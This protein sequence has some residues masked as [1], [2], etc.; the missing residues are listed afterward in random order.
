MSSTRTEKT[1][2]AEAMIALSK[3]NTT[4]FRNNV[5][6]ATYDNGT[7]VVYGLCPG[8]SDLIGWTP[9]VVREKDMGRKIAI[10]TAVEMK[11]SA[12]KKTSE[13]QQ[14]FLDAVRR[15]GGIACVGYDEG[16]VD[17]VVRQR[18]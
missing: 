10:F 12:K 16:V 7:R 13:A 3:A 18:G 11:R 8:S 1:A 2:K 17:E 6:V 4:V 9:H 14:R 5:G 15:D